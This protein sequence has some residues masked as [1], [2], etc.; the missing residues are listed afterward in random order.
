MNKKKNKTVKR[1]IYELKIKNKINIVS[2][3]L[4]EEWD[5]CSVD[6][7]YTEKRKHKKSLSEY[8]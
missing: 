3:L 8:M 2:E 4:D 6:D 5:Q 7:Y 1:L